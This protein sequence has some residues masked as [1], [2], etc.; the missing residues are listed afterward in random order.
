MN[1]VLLQL[2]DPLVFDYNNLSFQSATVSPLLLDPL[3]S[4]GAIVHPVSNKSQKYTEFNEHSSSASVANPRV[5]AQFL[6]LWKTCLRIDIGQ[7]Q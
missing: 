3:F 4:S 6:L 1:R 7:L 2:F 5:V